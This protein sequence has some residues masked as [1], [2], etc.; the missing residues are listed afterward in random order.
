MGIAAAVADAD[1]P[2]VASV[3][4]DRATVVLVDMNVRDG[5]A[6]VRALHLARPHAQVVALGVRDG[7]DVAAWANAGVRACVAC[8]APLAELAAAVRRVANGETACSA[9]LAGLLLE[10]AGRLVS[11]SGFTGSRSILTCREQEVADLVAVGLSNKQ[12]A[13]ALRVRVPTVKNH[14]HSILRKLAVRTRA[15]VADALAGERHT[16]E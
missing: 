8:E 5:V 3:A 1:A 6:A 15:D 4:R 9:R 12:I 2:L 11:G 7:H 13:S 10:R 16:R 14:V